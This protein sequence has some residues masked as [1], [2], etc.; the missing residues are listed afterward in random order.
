M[1]ISSIDVAG[2]RIL[3]FSILTSVQER[4]Q[5]AGDSNDSGDVIDSSDALVQGQ[6][7]TVYLIT[8]VVL[9]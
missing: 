1:Y 6:R 5:T 3:R 4:C 7:V 9:A 8:Q 2:A